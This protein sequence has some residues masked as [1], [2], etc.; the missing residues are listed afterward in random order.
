M[1]EQNNKQRK[2][3]Q[4]KRYLI[5]IG[6]AGIILV[7]SASNKPASIPPTTTEVDMAN[8]LP[9]TTQPEIKKVLETN[10][11]K[12]EAKNEVTESTAE[13]KEC[14]QNYSGCL[15]PNASDYDCAGGSG[16][17][18]YYT[19]PVQVLGYDPYGLDRDHDGWACDK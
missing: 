1:I 6:I 10:S 9:D 8:V 18:P 13:Q 14:N 4:K 19:G 5:P 7:A 2:W 11:T 15:K 16:D 12:I 3:Y 17:G